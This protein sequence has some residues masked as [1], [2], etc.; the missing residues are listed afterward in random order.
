M[1]DT[2][3]AQL[4]RGSAMRLDPTF[5]S[6]IEPGIS[7]RVFVTPNGDMRGLFVAAK[8]AGGFIVR[9]AQAG[10]STVSFDYRI[11]ATALGESGQRMAEMAPED[12][13]RAAA[14]NAPR[15]RR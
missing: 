10:R 12:A 15:H 11:V 1:E 4:E 5:A 7:Y 3:T 8:T 14:P 6:S 9:E 2:G 13:P